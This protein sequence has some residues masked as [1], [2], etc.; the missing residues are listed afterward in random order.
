MQKNKNKKAP[1]ANKWM[2]T[3]EQR[4]IRMGSTYIQT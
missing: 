1:E 3:H 4:K 2:W